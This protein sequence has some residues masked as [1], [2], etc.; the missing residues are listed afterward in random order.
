MMTRPASFI[1]FLSIA[2]FTKN[3]I[4]NT[5]TAIPILFARF[6][7]MNFSRSVSFFETGSKTLGGSFTST[8][9]SSFIISIPGGGVVGFVV[10]G[11]IT[12]VYYFAVITAGGVG[13][14]GI[15]LSTL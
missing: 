15:G 13:G 12:G 3:E 6:S 1:Q 2:Y 4:P 7:P 9:I 11:S 8:I 5:N 10:T 14:F